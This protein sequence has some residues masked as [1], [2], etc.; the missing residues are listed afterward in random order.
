[1]G[2][3]HTKGYYLLMRT[4]QGPRHCY[5]SSNCI[6]TDLDFLLYQRNSGVRL[7]GF[8]NPGSKK[9]LVTTLNPQEF[10]FFSVYCYVYAYVSWYIFF[11]FFFEGTLTLGV[12]SLSSYYNS[13]LFRLCVTLGSNV[14]LRSN[15]NY[16]LIKSSSYRK[17][18]GDLIMRR[19][20]RILYYV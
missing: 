18:L 10:R 20:L 1:M 14:F 15:C 5:N 6:W 19:V 3:G 12:S 9:G 17:Y 2:A 8:T 13:S 11:F 7:G 16:Q 4:R